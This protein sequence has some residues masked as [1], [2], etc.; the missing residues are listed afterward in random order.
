M[1]ENIY[2]QI[3]QMTQI[4]FSFFSVSPRLCVRRIFEG[5]RFSEETTNGTGEGADNCGV[6]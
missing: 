4:V 5:G 3:S 6:G 2:P 1:N